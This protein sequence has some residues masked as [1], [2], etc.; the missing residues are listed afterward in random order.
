M[1]SSSF[2]NININHGSVHTPPMLGTGQTTLE[3]SGKDSKRVEKI[4]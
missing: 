3:T 4:S 2:Q 1:D